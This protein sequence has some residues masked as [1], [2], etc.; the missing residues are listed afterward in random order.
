MIHHGNPTESP[1]E[2]SM[3]VRRPSEIPVRRITP[4]EARQLLDRGEATVVDVRPPEEYACDH[5]PG[6]ISAPLPSLMG[7]LPRLPRDRTIIFY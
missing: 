7:Y 4:A 6:A 2:A 3:A 1:G 5:I